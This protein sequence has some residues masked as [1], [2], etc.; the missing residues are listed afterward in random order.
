MTQ[1]IVVPQ[2]L[3]KLVIVD[4]REHSRT[5]GQVQT[6]ILGRPSHYCRITIPPGVWYA[7]QAVSSTDAILAN[8]ADMPHDP[9]ESES[10]A[11]DALEVNCAWN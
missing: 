7:F 5:C 6:V 11:L 9:S 1:N 3:I 10:A 4:P 2:G 8:C